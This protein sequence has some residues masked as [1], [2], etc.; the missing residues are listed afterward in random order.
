MFTDTIAARVERLVEGQPIC[1]GSL[2]V[3]PLMGEAEPGLEYDVYGAALRESVLV[4]EIDKG[5]RVGQ[6]CVENTLD[7]PVLILGGQELRGA[8]Q[9]RIVNVDVLVP[10]KSVVPIPVSCVEQGRWR[11]VGDVFEPAAMAP[12]HLRARHSVRVCASL[13]MS[14][15]FAGD[16]GGTWRDVAECVAFSGGA[17]ETGAM[18]AA[19]AAKE[20]EV[21]GAAEAIRLPEGA[22]GVMVHD[23]PRLMGLDVFDKPGTLAALWPILVRGH[24]MSSALRRGYSAKQEGGPMAEPPSLTSIR[25]FLRKPSWSVRPS[26][27]LGHHCTL[28]DERL[29]AAALVWDERVA[30][31]LQVFATGGA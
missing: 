17:S 18:R 25:E 6:L 4:R 23:G 30:V 5:G 28:R 15:S 8:K 12:S 24:A 9:D 27:G 11:A 22:V 19:F 16:Q 2:R 3:V 10:P 21:K 31:H 13:E 29:T 20:S 1:H 7:R 14:E 26:P